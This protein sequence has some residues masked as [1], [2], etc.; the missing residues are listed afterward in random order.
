MDRAGIG[1]SV[2]ERLSAVPGIMKV[3]APALDMFVLRGFLSGPEC[4]ALIALIEADRKPSPLMANH[5]D[6]TFRTSETCNLDRRH[7]TV[8]QIEVKLAALTGIHP[9]YGEAIQGQRYAVGQEF[10]PHHD[11]LRTTE[12]YWARQERVGGQRT[13][14]AMVFLNLPEQGGETVF[15]RAGVTIPP[16]RGSLVA[17]NNLDAQGEP[18]PATLHQGKPVTAGVKYI[19]TRWYRERPWGVPEPS[20]P[21]P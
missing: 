17:W 20:V 19:I 1:V 15:P 18:N 6:P 21:G 16:R 7:V 8:R 2:S 9:K 11:Y 13:W 12:S 14:T 5:P 10:K 3:P 4:E